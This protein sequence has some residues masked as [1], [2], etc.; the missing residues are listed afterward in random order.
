[1]AEADNMT[2][3]Q[4]ADAV[5]VKPPSVNAWLSSKS[6]FLRGENLLRAAKALGVSEVWLAE[7]KG[8]MRPPP[9]GGAS[10]DGHVD[11]E[12]FAQARACPTAR[13]RRNTPR[14]TGSSSGP[15][16]WRASACRPRA[17]R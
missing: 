16:R 1:M 11:V 15:T 12:G 14:H 5:G 9:P 4:L 7:G 17:W 6:K 8:P 3:K 13:R 10:A 2:Q